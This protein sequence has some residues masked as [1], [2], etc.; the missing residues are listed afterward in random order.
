MERNANRFVGLGS[1]KVRVSPADAV[2]ISQLRA[3]SV[4][5]YLAG[6]GIPRSRLSAEAF[7]S[8]NRVSYGT[9]LDG[10]QTNRRVNTIINYA[11][12]QRERAWSL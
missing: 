12:Y 6:L 9:T 4:V 11:K 3:Q 1:E 10:Q 5:N 8:T 7:G 2:K